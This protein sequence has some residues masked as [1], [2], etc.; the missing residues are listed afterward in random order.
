[1]PTFTEKNVLVSV[2]VGLAAA[3]QVTAFLPFDRGCWSNGKRL[4]NDCMEVGY[5]NSSCGFGNG[6]FN[7][8]EVIYAWMI[9][10]KMSTMTVWTVLLLITMA[11]EG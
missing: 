4:R 1:M 10:I 5:R 3:V 6:C 9:C 2:D 8:I 7:C 11:L